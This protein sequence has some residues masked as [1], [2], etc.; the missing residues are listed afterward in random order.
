MH[1][2]ASAHD[3]VG[4]AKYQKQLAEAKKKRDLQKARTSGPS[5]DEL[6]RRGDVA[7]KNIKDKMKPFILSKQFQQCIPLR[8]D[9]VKLQN[10]ITELEGDGDGDAL[11]SE[12]ARILKRHGA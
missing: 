7:A 3:F 8:E 4:A 6:R 11:R 12:I 9:L 10:A 5:P 1:E 2:C